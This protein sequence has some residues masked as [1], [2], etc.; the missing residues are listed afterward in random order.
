MGLVAFFFSWGLAEAPSMYEEVWAHLN[1]MET[2]GVIRKSQSPYASNVII[3]RKKSGALRFCIDQRAINYKTIPERYS[4]P[5]IDSIL[6]VLDFESDVCS[7][8]GMVVTKPRTVISVPTPRSHPS[9]R[10]V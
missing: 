6:D 10:R 1:E 3:V 2:L 8:K 7:N 4:L 9:N 5:C